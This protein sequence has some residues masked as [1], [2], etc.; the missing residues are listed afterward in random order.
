MGK[1]LS[2]R[3]ADG[4]LHSLPSRTRM[5]HSNIGNT[6]EI[7]NSTAICVYFMVKLAITAL[8]MFEENL[9]RHFYLRISV[10]LF[11]LLL[12]VYATLLYVLLCSWDYCREI[13]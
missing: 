13:D 3:V 9:Y 2:F 5:E 12:R 7:N 1:A 8:I 6:L 11:L 4:T 10:V